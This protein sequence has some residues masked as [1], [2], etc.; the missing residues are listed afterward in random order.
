MNN[1]CK[2][3]FS[4]DTGWADK[5]CSYLII[6][7]GQIAEKLKEGESCSITIS[8]NIYE[9]Y[10]RIPW[11]W[12]RSNK[13]KIEIK[14]GQNYKFMCRSNIRGWKICLALFYTIF[15][16]NRYIVLEKL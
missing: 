1:N 14:E 2:F 10:I 6:L 11:S 5:H 15:F 12:H 9:V 8:P 13:L 16:F 4:R 7:N 3:A